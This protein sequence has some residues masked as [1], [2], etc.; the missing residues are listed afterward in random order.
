MSAIIVPMQRLGHVDVASGTLALGE[1][2]ADPSLLVLV[3][4]IPPGRYEVL[5]DFLDDDDDL[6]DPLRHSVVVDFGSQGRSPAG[7]LVLGRVPTWGDRM[8]LFDAADREGQL[9]CAFSTTL[10]RG[11]Y[12]ASVEVDEQERPLRLTIAFAGEELLEA[13]RLAQDPP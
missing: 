12:P 8:A 13:E 9:E 7:V 2:D 1:R 11:R 6:E 5:T 10:G 4:S 3:H